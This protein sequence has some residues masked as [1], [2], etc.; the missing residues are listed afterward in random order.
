MKIDTSK[1]KGYTD[2]S[3]EDRLK[4][5][6]GFDLTIDYTGYIKKEDYDK[7]ASEAADYKKKWKA[8]LSE[9]EQLEIDEVEKRKD[10]EEKLE[11]LQNEKILS[12]YKAK[13]VALGY[14]EKIASET[15]Q[16]M[17]DGD[18]DKVF[19][20]Q[21]K[22]KKAQEAA[23]KAELLKSTPTPPAGNGDE[24]GKLSSE[25]FKAMSLA[26]KQ[27]LATEDPESYKE[28]YKEA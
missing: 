1:I 12:D 6:E 26:E 15:A 10:I 5:L 11:K 4:A 3:N 20:S 24:N 7:A 13:F 25:K 9:K 16:A 19:A 21:Q 23:I 27:K 17:L 14:D 2:M 8:T 18:M 22:F 28:F